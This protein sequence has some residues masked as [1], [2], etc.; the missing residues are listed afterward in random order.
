MLWSDLVVSPAKTWPAWS[1][2][3]KTACSV[4][5]HARKNSHKSKGL[6]RVLNHVDVDVLDVHITT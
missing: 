2:V 6:C 5:G 4:C 1:D 3:S